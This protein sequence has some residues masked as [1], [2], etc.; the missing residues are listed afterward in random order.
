MLIGTDRDFNVKQRTGGK[1][2]LLENASHGKKKNKMKQ[3]Q[4]ISNNSQRK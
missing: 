2:H 4:I 1:I 3:I